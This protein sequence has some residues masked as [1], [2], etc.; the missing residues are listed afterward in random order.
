MS[1]HPKVSSKRPGTRPSM[2]AARL[3]SF[4]EKCALGM[5]KLIS[6]SNIVHKN[7]IFISLQFIMNYLWLL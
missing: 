2:P 6:E 7:S 1:P 4:L 3:N 5:K